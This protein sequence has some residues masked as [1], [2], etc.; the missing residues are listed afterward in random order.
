MELTLQNQTMNL[1]TSIRIGTKQDLSFILD[2]WSKISKHIY[3]NQYISSFQED[4][5][6]YLKHLISNSMIIIS[7][8]Y[9]EPDVIV[10][11]LVYFVSLDRLFIHF[12]YTKLSARNEGQVSK[13]IQFANPS[14]LPIVFTHP[15]KNEN[16]MKSLCK[17]YV[18]N[19]T[20][21]QVLL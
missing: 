7:H 6:V 15:P 10:S 16:L 2:S 1:D 12:A 20:V 18:F 21:L 13:L 19:P 4:Y 3:P 5:N 9:N 11:Y 14:S 17:K 8:L